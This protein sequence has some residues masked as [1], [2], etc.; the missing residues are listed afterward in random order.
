MNPPRRRSDWRKWAP[1]RHSQGCSEARVGPFLNDDGDDEHEGASSGL[2]GCLLDVL[3]TLQKSQRFE[4]WGGGFHW[5]ARKLS[6]LGSYRLR[7]A[8]W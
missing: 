1:A 6:F 5:M 3:E 7:G 4:T 2:L 8:S